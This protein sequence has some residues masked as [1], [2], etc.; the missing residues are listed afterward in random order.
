MKA[1]W[2]AK[3]DAEFEA[4]KD[5]KPNKAD[6][7]DGR[8]SGLKA[9]A[10]I[11]TIRGAGKPASISSSSPATSGSTPITPITKRLFRCRSATSP[12]PRRC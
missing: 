9:G 2:R 8:W 10:R 1:A 3:L 5:Y 4:G 12:R 7:L 11:L 6:W